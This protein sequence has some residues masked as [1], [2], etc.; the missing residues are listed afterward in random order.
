M[1]NYL[2]VAVSVSFLVLTSCKETPEPPKVIY[3]DKA[4]ATTKPAADTARIQIADLPI[5]L[6]GTQYL[7]HP[8]ADLNISRAGSRRTNNSAMNEGGF[9]ISNYSEFE[10]TGYLRN[11]KFQKIGS[12]SLQVLTSKHVQIQTASFLKTFSEK[13]KRQLMVY[14]LTDMDTNK[15]GSLNADDIRALYISDIS[16]AGFTKLSHEYEEL[17]DWHVID[18][19]NRLYFRSIEDSNK[20]GE[21]DNADVIHYHY[22]DLNDPSFN[23]MSYNPI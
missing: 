9:Q 23:V 7:I 8:V 19:M 18:S 1:K 5:Q 2:L 17:I 13:S 15:D 6:E 10:I 11:I 12:D 14:T 4:K 20:N 22:V 21:F 16:G 3:D